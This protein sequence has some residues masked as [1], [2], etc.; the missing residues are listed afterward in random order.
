MKGQ[1]VRVR[2]KVKNHCSM[3]SR[4]LML[5][6]WNSKG[7]FCNVTCSC[8]ILPF[9]NLSSLSQLFDDLGQCWANGG[10]RLFCGPLALF[11]GP[12][13]A[14]CLGPRFVYESKCCACCVGKIQATVAT[15]DHWL[16]GF[17]KHS[18]SLCG[19][20]RENTR[21]RLKLCLKN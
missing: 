20:W 19:S 1:E 9:P 14:I 7:I 13:N 18:F 6:R 3:L 17:T 15:T 2:R 11:I 16:F 12:H 21:I 5:F 8:T 10:P 4:F